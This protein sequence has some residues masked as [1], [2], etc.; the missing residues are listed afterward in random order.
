M[1]FDLQ[2]WINLRRKFKL[3]DK[4]SCD[5][6]LR[7][8]KEV[9]FLLSQCTFHIY[10]I[11]II[12]TVQCCTFRL[13]LTVHMISPNFFLPCQHYITH[14]WT[15]A[16][17]KNLLTNVV[18]RLKKHK[19]R[20]IKVIL[21]MQVGTLFRRFYEDNMN[22]KPVEEIE[23]ELEE[24][25][26]STEIPEAPWETRICNVCGINKDDGKVLIC[27]RCEAYY[28]TYCLTPPLSQIPKGNWFCPICV[29]PQQDN[30][31]E[32]LENILQFVDKNCEENIKLLD[33]A[34]ALKE[35]EYW[36]L[37]ADKVSF[38]SLSLD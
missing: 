26:T 28:H 24:I 1:F 6:K 7:Y 31:A 38:L 4:M 21:L 11:V 14:L 18:I 30:E 15:R 19:V 5:F 25:L 23:K 20:F 34:T 10:V 29:P 17:H 16:W 32:G 36:E 13:F 37:D 2:V 35:K 8:E 22:R 27:D 33:I 9:C 12:I 3:V